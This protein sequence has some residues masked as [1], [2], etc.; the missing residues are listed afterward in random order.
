MSGRKIDVRFLERPLSAAETGR[1]KL[2]NER[3]Q[4]TRRL[5]GRRF[6]TPRRRSGQ[7]FSSSSA[8]NTATLFAWC[9]SAVSPNAL[10]GYSMELC[11]GT[12]VRATGEIDAFRIVREEAIAAGIR[13][14]EA[15]SGEAAREWAEEER[16]GRRKSLKGLRERKRTLRRCHRLKGQAETRAMLEANRCP[17][18]ASGKARGGSSRVGEERGQSERSEVEKSRGRDREGTCDNARGKENRCCRIRGWR[19]QTASSG[20]RCAQVKDRRPDFPGGRGERHV[21][22]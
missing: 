5:R 12:H 3:S 22:P 14:I 15:V 11:G 7:T 9:R 10:N 8:T 16:S 20:R 13:R 4:R 17:R 18:G 19:C 21:S 2:V 6:R 1:E